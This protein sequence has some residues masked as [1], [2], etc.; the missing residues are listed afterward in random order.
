MQCYVALKTPVHFFL[1]AAIGMGV[2]VVVGYV[3]SLF[4]PDDGK[5][6]DGLTIHTLNRRTES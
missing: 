2:T 1:Y 4:V 3:I 6:L 5:S